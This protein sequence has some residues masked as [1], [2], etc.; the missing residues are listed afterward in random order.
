[1]I[2]RHFVVNVTKQSGNTFFDKLC[3]ITYGGIV[4]HAIK[5]VS[6]GGEANNGLFFD[7]YATQP[8]VLIRSDS[9]SNE[10]D[11]GFVGL[12][13]QS[14]GNIWAGGDISALSFT[15]RTPAYNG[16]ALAELKMISSDEKGNIDH[17]TLPEFVRHTKN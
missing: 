5:L 1:M 4:Y 17:K 8:P 15:D 16:D 13:I 3:K 10:S 11:Y 12:K 6:T 14:D 9:G 2:R 7:G